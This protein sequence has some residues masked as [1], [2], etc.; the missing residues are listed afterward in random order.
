M[1]H[2]TKLVVV[3]LGIIGT[4]LGT[5]P[6]VA[7]PGGWEQEHVEWGETVEDF[8]DVAGL[9]V[10]DVG[11]GDTRSK[12]VG[13]GGVETSLGLSVDTDVYTN[14][15]NG[16][17]VTNVQN[18]YDE[19]YFTDN[20]DGTSTLHFFASARNTAY[21]DQGNVIAR[22]AGTVTVESVWDQNG[23]PDNLDDDFP[24]SFETVK[25]TGK[26]FDFCGVLVPALT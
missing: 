18:R 21:D 16:R 5:T 14:L 26:R 8:C 25:S 9:T 2:S 17:S 12:T 20:G 13:R 6:A 4:G 15:A 11:S 23:T 3:V 19:E 24:L 1:K 22:D 7:S 10:E